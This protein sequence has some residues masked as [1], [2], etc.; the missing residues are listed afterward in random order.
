MIDIIDPSTV[1]ETLQQQYE[2]VSH[3]SRD[4]I[5]EQYQ[6]SKMK[7][8]ETVLQFRAQLSALESQLN[9]VGHQTRDD[10]KLRAFASWTS[11]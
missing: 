3:A 4:A 10:E 9:G 7:P 11:Q 2:S 8:G 5:L 1:W 6:T